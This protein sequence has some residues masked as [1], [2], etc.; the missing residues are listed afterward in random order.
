MMSKYWIGK[1]QKTGRVVVFYGG[2]KGTLIECNHG[3]RINTYSEDW[4]PEVFTDITADYL[5]NTKIRIKSPEHSEFVQKLIFSA[6]GKWNGGADSVGWTRADYLFVNRWLRISCRPCIG[7]D[8]YFEK[9]PNKE[10]TLPLP[11]KE[12]EMPKLNPK[13]QEQKYKDEF[14]E[15]RL[16]ALNSC[17]TFVDKPTYTKEMC[18]R[19]ELPPVGS[20]VQIEFNDNWFNVTVEYVG[21]KYAIAKSK[22]GKEFCIKLSGDKW[23][24]KTSPVDEL[25]AEIANASDNDEVH[26][27]HELIAKAIIN[28]DIDLS[29]YTGVK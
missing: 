12:K 21:K 16:A 10:I 11:P 13:Q 22:K 26:P 7:N 19:G 24:A 28:G 1:T 2:S 14:E 8:D 27:S 5:R 29:K 23:R 4:S 6:G 17:H 25:A 18:E 9:H 3:G 15:V 20:E